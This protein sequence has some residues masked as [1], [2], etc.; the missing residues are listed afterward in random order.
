MMSKRS[1]V[2]VMRSTYALQHATAVLARTSE[3]KT[4]AMVLRKLYGSKQ[5]RNQLVD[6]TN[7]HDQHD[8]YN[9]IRRTLSNAEDSNARELGLAL[10]MGG[11]TGIWNGPASKRPLTAS[12][13]ASKSAMVPQC[14]SPLRAT[15]A[16]H[17]YIG[18][19][20]FVLSYLPLPPFASRSGQRPK[21]SL[22]R[23]LYNFHDCCSYSE[24][25]TTAKSFAT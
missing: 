10:P 13:C 8:Q 11:T 7:Q 22:F 16:L 21:I 6:T 1:V 14:P 2:T 5:P 25:T 23:T 18:T 19:R 24:A 9:E 3:M 20:L 17:L 12:T 15:G 4:A